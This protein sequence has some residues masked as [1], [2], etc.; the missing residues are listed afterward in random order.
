L[1]DRPF[2]KH[3]RI[4]VSQE[5]TT[6]I[7]A[8]SINIFA[9]NEHIEQPHGEEDAR[10]AARPGTWSYRRKFALGLF[11]D[12]LLDFLFMQEVQ[13]AVLLALIARLDKKWAIAGCGRHLTWEPGAKISLKYDPAFQGTPILYNA[14]KFACIAY[15]V[16]Y[17]QWV[18][19][20]RCRTVAI[21]E[22]KGVKFPRCFAVINNHSEYAWNPNANVDARTVEVMTGIEPSQPTRIINGNHSHQRHASFRVHSGHGRRPW[23]ATNFCTNNMIVVP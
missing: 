4:R 20:P 3:H 19:I 11:D 17:E 23:K 18:V 15:W 14:D 7:K 13:R 2:L 22:E 16:N 21:F 1:D 6:T 10:Q 8:P 12:P 9:S 5:A